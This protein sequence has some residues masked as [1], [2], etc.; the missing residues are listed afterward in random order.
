MDSNLFEK[1]EVV[2]LKSTIVNER[3]SI[4]A[5]FLVEI[6]LERIGSKYKPLTGRAVAMKC[7][8]IPTKDL[9]PFLSNAKDYQNRNGSFSKYFFGALRVK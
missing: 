3:Q 9:Y 1:Y 8:H 6:N 4:L 5:Q 7:S 2:K